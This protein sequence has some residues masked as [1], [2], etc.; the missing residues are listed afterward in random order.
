MG[1]PELHPADE[2]LAQIR[3]SVRAL[4]A[5][6]PGEYW[7]RLDR[8][9][10]YPSEFVA[11]L[12]EAGFLAA[13]IPEEY[14]GSGLTMTAAAAIMEEIH[15]AGCNGAACHA[16]M[17]T[18]GTVLRHGSAAVGLANTHHLG[19]IGHWGE[20]CANAGVVSVHFVNVR[21]R[22]LVAPWGEP[23]R[24][25]RRTR[26]ALPSR[27]HPIRWCSTMRPRRWR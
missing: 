8:E 22:P 18:M 15:A 25:C 17:Y 13:L 1:D 3:E 24:A 2:D 20:Q 16:Q 23:T 27:M 5:R 4:C 26:S 21:S 7:R 10:G 19:R 14:G 9:R 11:A 12:T 6:F